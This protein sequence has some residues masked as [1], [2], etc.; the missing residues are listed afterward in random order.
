MINK[1]E[2]LLSR[3]LGRT[4]RSLRRNKGR[5]GISLHFSETVLKDNHLLESME[6]LR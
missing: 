1:N 3:R 6:W 5:R 4:R 2:S